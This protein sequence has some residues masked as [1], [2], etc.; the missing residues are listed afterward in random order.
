[1]AHRPRLIQIIL[2]ILRVNT[3]LGQKLFFGQSFFGNGKHVRLSYSTDSK[4]PNQPKDE[5]E[6]PE[7]VETLK[8]AVDPLVAKNEELT[9]NLTEVK[10]A[11]L[12]VLADSENLRVR[13]EKEKEK[14]KHLAIK[15]FASDLLSVADVLEMALSAV[16][17]EKR[18]G[19]GDLKNLYEGLSLTHSQLLQTF[20]RNGLKPMDDCVGQRYDPNL[21]QA[22]FET[23]IADKEKGTV[24]TVTKK[25]YMLHSVVLRAAQV[26]IV[27]Q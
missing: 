22:M 24:F 7:Q 5:S 3:R 12:R 19:D 10:H 13:T 14:A 25:G 21:Q 6:S 20:K 15:A 11:Y 4:D 23:P 8:E 16:P 1:M 27:S 17:E 18:Q 2:M 26:G 9:K